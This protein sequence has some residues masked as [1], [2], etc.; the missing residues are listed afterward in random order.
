MLSSMSEA[1]NVPAKSGHR[2]LSVVWLLVLIP[3]ALLALILLVAGSAWNSGFRSF[4]NISSSMEPAI[5]KGDLFLANMAHRNAID[6]D[7][8]LFQRDKT[9]LIKRVIASGGET[10]Q[11]TNDQIY[12]N[13]ALLS[14][15]YVQHI[16]SPWM[17]NFGPITVPAGQYFVMGDSRDLSFDSRSSKFGF[18]PEKSIIGKPLLVL[19]NPQA[20]RAGKLIQ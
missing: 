13:G 18:V 6:R 7:I 10:I 19:F 8:V 1:P 14:E 12:V 11:G 3:G 20:H 5:L 2:R 15:S 4:T 16:G 9:I 17:P